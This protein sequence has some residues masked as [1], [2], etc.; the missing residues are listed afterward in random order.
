MAMAAPPPAPLAAMSESRD[1][2]M[3]G[4][5]DPVLTDE[6]DVTS[7]FALAGKY[8]VR[9]GDTVSVP[10]LD[11]GVKAEMV[12]LFRPESGSEH[13]TAAAMID[14]DSGISL[15]PGI[16]TVYD[17]KQG[18]VGDAQIAALPTGEKQAVSFALDQ[19]VS[20]SSQP[21]SETTITRIKVVDGMIDTSSITRED[22]I[23]EIK[24]ASDA[25]RTVVIEQEKR[26]GWTFKGDDMIDG[27]VTKD[28][29]KIVLKAGETKAVKAS[30]SLVNEESTSLADAEPDAL[31]QWQDAATDP[32]IRANL[33]KLSNAKA[34]QEA[35]TRKLDALNDDFARGEADQQRARSNLQSVG[36]GDTKSRFEKLLNTAEDKLEALE[37]ARAEQRKMI[38]AASER[39]AS[40]IKSF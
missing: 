38:D 37:K 14:N 28:R 30:L 22:T 36:S 7:T 3:A 4:V 19:K 27:T 6:G 21:N 9:N 24:G 35:A 39:V 33:S 34:E 40:V 31:L 26:P 8:D 25:P 23:Y 13:P 12:S 2:L 16:I 17:G 29:I 1:A 18:Y 10:I 20:I 5:A 32:L 11:K 15:P